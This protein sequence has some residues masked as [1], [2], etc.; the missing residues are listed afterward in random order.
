MDNG[1]TRSS[2]K[3]KWITDISSVGAGLLCDLN[4]T[5]AECAQPMFTTVGIPKDSYTRASNSKPPKP[6]WATPTP[7]SPWPSTPKPPSKPT[8]QPPTP[9]V[10]DSYAANGEILAAGPPDARDGRAMEPTP[11]PEGRPRE[12]PRPG[13]LLVGTAGFEPA[14]SA[15]RTLR[16]AKLRHVPWHRHVTRSRNRPIKGCVPHIRSSYRRAVG[17]HPAAGRL[18]LR[19]VCTPGPSFTLAR[20]N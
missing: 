4:P 9:S 10:K 11:K 5:V 18:A 1:H 15:S 14:T 7:A 13:D 17:R 6:D 16:A 12:R 8:G 2:R 19:A 3:L 20:W